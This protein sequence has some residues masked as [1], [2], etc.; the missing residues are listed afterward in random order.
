MQ[1]N[2]RLNMKAVAFVG[3]LCVLVCGFVVYGVWQKSARNAALEGGENVASTT[4]TVFTT[5]MRRITVQH[6]YKDGIHTLVGS[7]EVPTP[8]HTIFAEPLFV[9]GGSAVEVRFS[10]VSQ[11][12]EDMDCMAVLADAPFSVSFRADENIEMRALWNGELAQFNII[13]VGPDEELTNSFDV[14]G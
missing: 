10:T 7:A 5:D 1:Y 9:E 13:P 11:L 6:Q 8:C 3:F 4:D 14:K 12:S 2:H